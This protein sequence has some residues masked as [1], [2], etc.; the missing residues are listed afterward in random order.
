MISDWVLKIA[1]PVVDNPNRRES[2][3]SAAKKQPNDIAKLKKFMM[4]HGELVHGSLFPDTDID[5]LTAIVLRFVHDNIFQKV[6]FGDL[7][8]PGEVITSIEASMQ[9]NVEPKRGK[10]VFFSFLWPTFTIVG[11]FSLS[12]ADL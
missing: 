1:E 11:F 5:V 4:N 9:T 10:T 3:I 7:R 6:L 2:F 12:E 8:N